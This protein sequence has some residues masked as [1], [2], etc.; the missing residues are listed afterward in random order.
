MCIDLL[1]DQFD[2]VWVWQYFVQQMVY[3]VWFVELGF[4]FFG[5]YYK[6][7]VVYVVGQCGGNVGLYWVV[8]QVNVWG[9]QWVVS[10]IDD[11]LLIWCGFIFEGDVQCMVNKVGVV[12]VG[13]QLVCVYCFLFVVWFFKI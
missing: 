2:V 6:F 10:D 3:I 13:Y 8:V 5:N 12:V 4:G 1:V 7:K 11:D 9:G